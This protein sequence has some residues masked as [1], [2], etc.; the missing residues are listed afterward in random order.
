M[1]NRMLLKLLVLSLQAV[2]MQLACSPAN[3]DSGVGVDTQIGNYLNSYPHRPGPVRD[4]DGIGLV[5]DSRSP[6]GFLTVQPALPTPPS[7]RVDD[8]LYSASGEAGA[9]FGG[10]NKRNAYFR[11]YRDLENG[12]LL[13]NF[14][15]TAEQPKNALF[16]EAFG[17]GVGRDDQFYG[18]TFGR[19]NDFRVRVFYNETVHV[20]TDTFSNFWGGIGTSS[21]TL[22]A[23]TPPNGGAICSN[24]PA[25]TTYT[26]PTYGL[27][28]PTPTAGVNAAVARS[29]DQNTRAADDIEIGL[30]RKKGGVRIDL[31][32]TDRI[33]VYVSGTSEKRTGARPFGGTWAAGGGGGNIETVEPIDYDTHDVYLGGEYSD[34]QN[35]FNLQMQGSFF[36]N[37]ISTFTFQNP[38]LPA[39]A[40][41]NNGA[42]FNSGRYDLYP[43]NDFYNIKAEYGRLI[44]QLNNGRFTAVVSASR[45]MQNDALIPT[46]LYSN[47]NSGVA[48]GMWDTLDSLSQKKSNA[49]IDT[50]LVDLGLVMS[51]LTALDV[52]GKVRYYDTDNKTEYLSC[53]PL[54]GQFGRFVNEG[55]GSAIPGFTTDTGAALSPARQAALNAFLVSN[56]CNKENL[57]AY[58]AANGLAPNTGALQIQNVPYEYKQY[59]YNLTADYRLNRYN[60]V[61]AMVE[62]EEYKRAHRERDETWENK[63]KLTYVNRSLP[64]G[65]IRLSGEFDRR[66]G[67]AYRQD[68]N[69]EEYYSEAFGAPTAAGTTANFANFIHS[70]EQLRKFDLADRDQLIANGRFNYAVRPD[71]DA[72][73]SAQYRDAKFPNSEFGRNG[74]QR[75]NSVNVDMNWQPAATMNVYAGYSYQQA[76]TEQRDVWANG[77][78]GG[79]TYFF[80]S[81]G[82]VLTAAGGAATPATPAGTSLVATQLV[83]GANYRD[84]CGVSTATSPLFPTSRAFKVQQDDRNHVVSLGFNYDFGRPKL[85][86]DYVA[87]RGRTGINYEYNAAALGITPLQS[88]I[89]G[90]RWPD[91][92][93]LQQ[94]LNTSLLI[95]VSKTAAVRL[96]WVYEF[97]RVDDWHYDGVAANPT[98]GAGTAFNTNSLYLD[99]GPAQKWRT[100]LFGIFFRMAL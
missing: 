98:A 29:L 32:A 21:L 20:F 90:D 24:P 65:T 15:I 53:N 73:V 88:G 59:V 85:S 19:Y 66:R 46:S 72:S 3:A 25:C 23:G 89:S 67:S 99:T 10:G 38:Y 54:T 70:P 96:L 41:G 44:P 77:C 91:M 2:G 11:H 35:S 6:T 69:E 68:P 51:P 97:G 14:T 64:G 48:G 9:L 12:F 78:V 45:L 1:K 34:D 83:T 42:L 7:N 55:T 13:N 22:P 80:Y 92:R 93:Y 16:V 57:A 58:A 37:N 28:T 43:N 27:N 95:P 39:T 18:V 79:N 82:Q 5:L 26:A 4:P 94:N 62:R 56:G 33:K 76:H 52:R 74:H 49:R 17:G 86:V 100:N 71:L 31:F 50:R 47:L 61:T 40:L 75:L 36:R 81:N 8:W 63:A 84:V 30:K 60:I 87:T